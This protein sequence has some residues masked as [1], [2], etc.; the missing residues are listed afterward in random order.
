MTTRKLLAALAAL[1][2]V[3]CGAG[4]ST[5]SVTQGPPV[6]M[7]K[8]DA[9]ADVVVRAYLAAIAVD[10]EVRRCDEEPPDDDR[11]WPYLFLTGRQSDDAPWKV[12]GYG[13]G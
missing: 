12:I 3:C 11:H 9:A 2:L 1:L 6:T 4:C 5:C 10:I 13:A 7:P 8:R